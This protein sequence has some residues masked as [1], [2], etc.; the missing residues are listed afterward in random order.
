MLSDEVESLIYSEDMEERIALAAKKLGV[1]IDRAL[2]PAEIKRN[3]PKLRGA[4]AESLVRQMR[5][6][7]HDRRVSRNL[8]ALETAT[9]IFNRFRI[10]P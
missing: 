9:V 2:S 10:I 7:P 4:I 6:Q 3:R 5:D 1:S 8:R